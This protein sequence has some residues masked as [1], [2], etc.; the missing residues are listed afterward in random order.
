MP[1][2]SRHAINTYLIREMREGMNG[3]RPNLERPTSHTVQA[4]WTKSSP[5]LECWMNF[6]D[7][8]YVHLFL[9]G[10]WKGRDL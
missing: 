8:L 4:V 1:E 2:H 9:R 7:I 10:E 6:P 5:R 3:K